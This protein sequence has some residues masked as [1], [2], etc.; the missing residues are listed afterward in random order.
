MIRAALDEGKEVD[1]TQDPYY[2]I[3]T[4]KTLSNEL[5]DL[6]EATWEKEHMES[7]ADFVKYYNNGD[8]IG[9]V[10]A[11]ENMSKIYEDLNLDIFKDA[12]TL[13]KLMQKYIFGR[14]HEDDDIMFHCEET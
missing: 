5:V 3:L 6:C 1:V 10:T 14:L 2:S 11:I 12:V 7:F 4:D 13:S 8:C 9:L